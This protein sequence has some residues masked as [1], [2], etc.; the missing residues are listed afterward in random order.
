MPSRRL[1][2]IMSSASAACIWDHTLPRG[3][4]R[5]RVCKMRLWWG[6]RLVGSRVKITKLVKINLEHVWIV[7]E[8]RMKF[9][10]LQHAIAT[11]CLTNLTSRNGIATQTPRWQFKLITATKLSSSFLPQKMI[12]SWVLPF[13]HTR[14]SSMVDPSMDS[15][16]LVWISLCYQHRLMVGRD[17]HEKEKGDNQRQ[18]A[19]CQ[20]DPWENKDTKVEQAPQGDGGENMRWGRRRAWHSSFFSVATTG[21]FLF[22]GWNDT[23]RL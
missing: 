21:T 5:R 11:S 14:S 4:T 8:V 17:I 19:T 22:S 6:G 3:R 15:H 12:C 10:D 9:N 1:A 23:L 18:H 2:C 7:E 16:I 13:R 20:R